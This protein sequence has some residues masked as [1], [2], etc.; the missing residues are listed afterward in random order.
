MNPFNSSYGQIAYFFYRNIIGKQSSHFFF[1]KN[2]FKFNKK[3]VT[4][5]MSK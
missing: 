4:K 2:L 3:C 1:Y 5:F